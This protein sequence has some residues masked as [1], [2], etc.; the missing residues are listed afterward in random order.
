MTTALVKVMPAYKIMLLCFLS[1]HGEWSDVVH[2][3]NDWK[4][5]GASPA[6]PLSCSNVGVT[7]FSIS[8]IWCSPNAVMSVAWWRMVRASDLQPIGCRFE[9]R[10]LA[11]HTYFIHQ[12]NGEAG[13]AP[14]QT[15]SSNYVTTFT[16][17]QIYFDSHSHRFSHR[18]E[19]AHCLVLNPHENSLVYSTLFTVHGRG[20][21]TIVVFCMAPLNQ[22]TFYSAIETIE[23]IVL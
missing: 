11:S 19:T 12:I 5:A 17:K 20:A 16:L 2:L 13:S 8:S 10:P 14:I 6:V 7:L 23:T 18:P 9:S 1:G 21:V 3:S 4:V 15:H 22:S